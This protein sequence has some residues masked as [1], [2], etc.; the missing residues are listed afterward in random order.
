MKKNP[1]KSG[2]K[3]EHINVLH[4]L[5]LYDFQ[6]LYAFV[7]FQRFRGQNGDVYIHVY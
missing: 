5:F 3:C 7:D 2:L 6:N 1:Q 4:Y